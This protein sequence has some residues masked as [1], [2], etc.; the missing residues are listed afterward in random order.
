M[1]STP[2]PTPDATPAPTPPDRLREGDPERLRQQRRARRRAA[3][4]DLRWIIRMVE[5]LRQIEDA[6]MRH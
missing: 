5:G 2:P 6:E 3:Q 4:I 1:S